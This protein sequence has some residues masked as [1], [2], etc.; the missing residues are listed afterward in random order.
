MFQGEFDCTTGSLIEPKMEAN[1]TYGGGKSNELRDFIL[2]R[3][4]LSQYPEL[5]SSH[6]TE[7]DDALPSTDRLHCKGEED[8]MTG[9][10]AHPPPYHS[11]PVNSAAVNRV[12]EVELPLF[13]LS[14]AEEDERLA[15]KFLNLSMSGNKSVAKLCKR[16]HGDTTVDKRCCGFL[17]NCANR[18]QSDSSLWSLSEPDLSQMT[19]KPEHQHRPDSN[20]RAHIFGNQSSNINSN[21]TLTV[22]AG[23]EERYS[24]L[25]R[26]IT[27]PNAF[28]NSSTFAAAGGNVSSMNEQLTSGSA[29][30]QDCLCAHLPKTISYSNKVTQT[31]G[32]FDQTKPQQY[33]TG[34]NSRGSSRLQRF[35]SL[36]ETEK[37]LYSSQTK[38]T[39]AVGAEATTAGQS[40]SGRSVDSDHIYHTIMEESLLHSA[41]V[42]L[43]KSGNSKQ[44]SKREKE[45]SNS[46]SLLGR[47]RS[48]KLEELK[49]KQIELIKNG[50]F[51]QS[52]INKVHDC[53]TGSLPPM[54]MSSSG[55]GFFPGIFGPI[56]LPHEQVGEEEHR[57]ATSKDGIPCTC[58]RCREYRG[59]NLTTELL[60]IDTQ[61]PL[62]SMENMDSF[63]QDSMSE[64]VCTII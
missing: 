19:T 45:K 7:A 20:S 23:T 47:A 55:K 13:Y 56:E 50:S 16:S 17:C 48:L 29:D 63:F 31:D 14:S 51:R 1:R 22:S 4:Y 40:F 57:I 41:P 64:L 26:V 25:S 52:P 21:G 28:L 27:P 43:G 18:N 33:T 37:H 44:K 24:H 53:R 61:I 49:Q 12:T 46:S 54:L 2:Y 6:S 39:T 11:A 10:V 58:H 38:S 36:S 60:P 62:Q 30:Y 59:L 34:S 9:A 32:V 5:F 35:N 15:S 8:S 42:K 3:Y